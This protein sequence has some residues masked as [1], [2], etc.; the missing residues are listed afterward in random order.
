MQINKNLEIVRIQILLCNLLEFRDKCGVEVGS[1]RFF[2]FSRDLPMGTL[3]KSIKNREI[4]RIPSSLRDFLRSRG[5]CGVEFRSG[6]F[7]DFSRN[8]P[9]GTASQPAS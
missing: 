9:M 1:G 4:I 8:L 5:E 3:P 7:L 6:R 2:D